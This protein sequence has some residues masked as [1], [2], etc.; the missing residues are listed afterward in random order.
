MNYPPNFYSQI[1]LALFKRNPA[2]IIQIGVCDGKINDPIYNCV[3]NHILS[4][5]IIL[6]EPQSNLNDIIAKNY[7][8][9]GNSFIENCAIG[10]P[11]IINFYRLKKEFEPIFEQKYMLD[12]PK[13]RVLAGFVSSNYE[14]VLKHI[15]GNLPQLENLDEA[16]EKFSVLSVSLEKIQHKYKLSD[17]NLLQIDA[18]GNDDVVI[19]HS[20]LD[21]IKPRVINFEHFNLSAGRKN[22]VYKY[23]QTYGYQL[24]TYSHSDTLACLDLDIKL[25]N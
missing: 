19:Y 24:H 5:I 12:V 9:H 17:Y 10:E 4:D 3:K 13:S 22:N 7:A 20:N 8:F 2:K 18:E 16:I 23:L 6:I 14:H 15:E 11:G 21:K 1:L 25:T